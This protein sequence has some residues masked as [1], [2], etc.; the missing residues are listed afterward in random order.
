MKSDTSKT[1]RKRLMNL[2]VFTVIFIAVLFFV[3][4]LFYKTASK[5]SA[6]IKNSYGDAIFKLREFIEEKV[7]EYIEGFKIDD[8][9]N[10]FPPINN[11]G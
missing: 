4:L 9:E 1:S 2:I 10:L 6:T 3:C 7:S 5:Y 11:S 8:F